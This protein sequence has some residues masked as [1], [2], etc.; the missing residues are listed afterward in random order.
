[1]RLPMQLPALIRATSRA[2]GEGG[3]GEGTAPNVEPAGCC[4]T[5]CDVV[6]GCHCVAES[7]F[8]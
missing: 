3:V 6:T 7:P 4:L 5:V 8:C 1:M 2:G